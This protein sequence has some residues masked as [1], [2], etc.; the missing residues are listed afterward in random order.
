LIFLLIRSMRPP[1]QHESKYVRN[2]TKGHKYVASCQV[3]S[4]G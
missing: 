2:V 3:V 1:G 4:A